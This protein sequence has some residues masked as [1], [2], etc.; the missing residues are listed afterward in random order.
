MNTS[1]AGINKEAHA[2][3]AFTQMEV[4]YALPQSSGLSL[5]TPPSED[6]LAVISLVAS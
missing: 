4:R 6:T 1:S 5:F 3:A 2:L